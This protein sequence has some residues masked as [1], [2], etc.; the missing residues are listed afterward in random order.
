MQ[1]TKRIRG[2]DT[3]NYS[4]SCIQQHQQ[5]QRKRKS[6]NYKSSTITPSVHDF[7]LKSYTAQHGVVDLHLSK[8]LS[9]FRCV[10]LFCY[11][12]DL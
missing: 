9:E 10:V 7:I 11:A 12:H 3:E 4:S 6:A 1:Q 2:D 5:P 8:I